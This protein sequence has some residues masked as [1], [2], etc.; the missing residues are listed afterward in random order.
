MSIEYLM[1][2]GLRNKE[3]RQCQPKRGY[4]MFSIKKGTASVK[5]KESTWLHKTNATYRVQGIITSA[6]IGTLDISDNSMCF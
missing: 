4:M 6:T 3:D 1:S 2:M 5:D